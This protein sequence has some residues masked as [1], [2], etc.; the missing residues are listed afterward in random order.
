M[1]QTDFLHAGRTADFGTAQ[2]VRR[3]HGYWQPF[4]RFENDASELRPRRTSDNLA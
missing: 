2:A 3:P 1:P 4:T